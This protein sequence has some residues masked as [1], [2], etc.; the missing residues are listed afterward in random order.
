MDATRAVIVQFVLRAVLMAAGVWLLWDAPASV[1]GMV[2][3]LV[4]LV[5]AVVG[6]TSDVSVLALEKRRQF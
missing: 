4:G 6:V 3:M 1:P 5:C 2:E